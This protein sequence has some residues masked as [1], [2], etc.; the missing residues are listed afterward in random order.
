MIIQWWY[1]EKNIRIDAH[2]SNRITV[3]EELENKAV[4]KIKEKKFYVDWSSRKSTL[5]I[6]ME[7]DR[8]VLMK[9]NDKRREL[10]ILAER[11][12]DFL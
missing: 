6:L 10:K 4:R 7:I 1:A 8:V 12:S 5:V 3:H 11:K 9:S 2:V